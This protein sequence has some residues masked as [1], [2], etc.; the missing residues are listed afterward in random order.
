MGDFAAGKLLPGGV[1]ELAPVTVAE[2]DQFVTDVDGDAE[3]LKSVDHSA[4]Q[5]AGDWAVL[6]QQGVIT[7][8][9]S[10]ELL[11]CLKQWRDAS[12]SLY[13]NGNSYAI[14]ENGVILQKVSETHV[15]IGE[16]L[17]GER[18]MMERATGLLS[19]DEVV[20]G[21]DLAGA[22]GE[23]RDKV[24]GKKIEWA[25]GWIEKT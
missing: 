16:D 11:M 20:L 12:L 5:A 25:D 6:E 3:F 7:V 2:F 14:Y 19:T 23:F 24:V 10:S 17:D 13:V 9:T 15:I 1:V 18:L 4:P 22:L 21:V 8:G